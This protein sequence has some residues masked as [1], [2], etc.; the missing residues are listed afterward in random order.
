MTKQFWRDFFVVWILRL[1]LPIALLSL[2]YTHDWSWRWW[3]AA[4]F[5]VGIVIIGRTYDRFV[6]MEKR[7]KELERDQ[8][9]RAQRIVELKTQLHEM[10]IKPRP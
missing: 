6:Y 3:D 7:I 5:T 1:C 10:G 2:P 4:M 8:W 9:I